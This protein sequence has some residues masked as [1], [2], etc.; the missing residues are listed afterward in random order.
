MP[1]INPADDIF[2]DTVY[3]EANEA[4]PDPIFLHVSTGHV[5]TRLSHVK[6]FNG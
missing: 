6:E 5:S 3:Q 4:S 1:T 2:L